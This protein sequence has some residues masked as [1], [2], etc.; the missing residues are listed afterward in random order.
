[1][2]LRVSTEVDLRSLKRDLK[3]LREL[4]PAYRKTVPGRMKAA[5]EPMLTAAK[6]KVPSDPPS[7][8]WSTSTQSRTG[9]RPARIRQRMVLKFRT[10]GF[11]A[12]ANPNDVIL[13]MVAKG[14]PMSIF[15]MAKNSQTPRTAQWIAGL[16]TRY[17]LPSRVMWRTAE[18]YLPR[19]QF[20]VAKVMDEIS[21]R[22]DAAIRRNTP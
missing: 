17:G 1:M 14:A 6:A 21:H 11:K 12:S 8:G 9:W 5:A 4:E 13:R 7:S 2:T 15:D 20:E 19:V 10:S 18:Q 3:T 16:N 22:A